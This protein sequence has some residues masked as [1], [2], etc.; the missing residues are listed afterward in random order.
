MQKKTS[1]INIVCVFVIVEKEILCT[2]S[3][4]IQFAKFLSFFVQ[5]KT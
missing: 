2:I 1:Q 3:D 5:F 4:V